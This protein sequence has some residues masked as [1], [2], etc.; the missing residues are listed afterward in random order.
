MFDHLSFAVKNYD[1]SLKFYD[2]T[3]HILGYKREVT[4]E[5]PQ[6]RGAGYGNGGVRPCLWISASGLEEEQIGKAKGVHIAFVAPNKEAV[7]AWY[8]KCLELGGQD[9]G[10]PGPRAHYHAGYYGAF[11]IDPNGWRIEAC[12]H[13]YR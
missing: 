11:V 7:L 8:S 3:L 12:I 1:A 13:N 4:L 6:Y 10:E 5:L 9:N 2:E